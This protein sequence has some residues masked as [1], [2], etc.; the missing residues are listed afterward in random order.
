M[1][2]NKAQAEALAEGFLNNLGSGGGDF[3]PKE[4]FTEIILIAGEL[5]ADAQA[6]LIHSNKHSTGNLSAS[7]VAEDPVLNGSILSVDLK[8]LFYGLF[9]NSGVKGT[10]S[11][12][13]TAGYSFKNEFPSKN[14][15]KAI[16][17]WIQHA[18]IATRTIKKDAGYGRHEIKQKSIAEASLS[19]AYAI[20]KIVKQKGLKPTGFFDKAVVN[21]RRKYGSRIGAA[22]EIDLITSITH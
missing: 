8:M 15:V 9:V 16:R 6:N 7:L 18:H 17:E 1:S 19:S 2:I 5:I 11:G 10:R 21:A 12:A 13:S 20:A 22:L 14:M 4:T 3:E